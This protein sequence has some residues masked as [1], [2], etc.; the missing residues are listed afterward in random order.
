M[1]YLLS[2]HSLSQVIMEKEAQNIDICENEKKKIKIEKFE[3]KMK[4]K[5]ESQKKKKVN[6]EEEE[7]KENFTN[8][9]RAR[10]IRIHPTDKQEKTLNE[11]FG[12]VRFI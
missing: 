7:Q 11:W 8:P 6:V 12:G 4:I 5:M 2:Q 10:R 1:T 9:F 3:K